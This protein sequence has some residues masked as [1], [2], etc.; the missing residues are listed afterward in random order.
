MR[1]GEALDAVYKGKDVYRHISGQS[2][3]LVLAPMIEIRDD[4][5]HTHLITLVD[6]DKYEWNE[7]VE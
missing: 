7:S 5:G 6:A 2:Q 3:R 4:N 1:F